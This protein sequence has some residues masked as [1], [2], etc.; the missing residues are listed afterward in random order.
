LPKKRRQLSLADYRDLVGQLNRPS[1]AQCEAFT[2]FVA[3]AHSWYKHLSA[4]PPG[5]PFTFFLDLFAGCDAV[6]TRDGRTLLVPRESQGFHYSA[7][8]TLEYRARFGHLAYA[9]PGATRVQR[10]RG[11]SFVSLMD[12]L[13]VIAD[14]DGRWCSLPREVAE[15]GSVGITALIHPY[16]WIIL[17]WIPVDRDF[18]PPESGGRATLQ[19]A[20]ARARQLRRDPKSR[21]DFPDDHPAPQTERYIDRVL[22]DLLEPERRRQRSAMLLAIRRMLDLVYG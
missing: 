17:E 20:V 7:L 3:T 5:S 16:A 12:H 21:Q 19:Q 14:R 4:A 10:T 22:Y 8:P 1:D 2:R 11:D 9:H 15:V 18:L 13:H 6:E